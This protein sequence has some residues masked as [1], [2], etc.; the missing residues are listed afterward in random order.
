LAAGAI[1]LIGTALAGLLRRA[2]EALRSRIGLA[3]A[4]GGWLPH[5]SVAQGMLLARRHHGAE[6]AALRAQAERLSRHFGLD[7]MPRVTPHELGHLDLARAGCARAFLGRPDLLLLESPFDVEAA[8]TLVAPLR[9]TLDERRDAGAAAIWITRS[10]RA[11]DD[12]A[13]PATQRLRLGP[14]GLVRA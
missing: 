11:W 12:P 3:P 4:E 10:R 6:E 5:L 14:E 8:D 9:A 13:F 7:G 2:A 1:G